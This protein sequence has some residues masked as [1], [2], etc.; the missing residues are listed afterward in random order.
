M[1]PVAPQETVRDAGIKPE[2]AVLQMETQKIFFNVY[3][4]LYLQ[5]VSLKKPRTYLSAETNNGILFYFFLIS[6]PLW[7]LYTDAVMAYNLPRFNAVF[8]QPSKFQQFPSF[9]SSY[10]QWSYRYFNHHFSNIWE[11]KSAA[12]YCIVCVP[13]P[14]NHFA[15]PAGPC[16]F[17]CLI[18]VPVYHKITA[19]NCISL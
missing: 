1:I 19:K 11:G 6:A 4:L 10:F 8:F 12:R 9:N 7:G 13:G 5:K 16:L 14:P 2:T 17:Y 15:L 18:Q 3:S